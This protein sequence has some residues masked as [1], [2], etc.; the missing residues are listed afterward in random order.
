MPTPSRKTPQRVARMLAMHR[1]GASARE[2]A[3]D[4]D[5][6]H[7]TIN[8]W[9]HEAGLEPN[10]GQGSRKG[11]Q[12]V[13]PEGSAAAMAE[14]QRAL[15][16]LASTP[17]PT[18]MGGV[19][20]RLRED[21]GLVSALVEFHVQGARAGTSTMT[22]LDKAIAIQDRFAARLVELTPREAP[23]PA[24]DPSNLE[25]AAEVRREIETAVEAMERQ[26]TCTH[27]GRNPFS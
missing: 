5:V 6:S 2:I 3:E 10:G 9:L 4:L 25:A 24:K 8:A 18:D 12:R 20:G 15:A 22:E 1:E 26:C 14:A 19:L 17:A 23:D 16:E 7:P 13:T 21:F 11:R 27:C